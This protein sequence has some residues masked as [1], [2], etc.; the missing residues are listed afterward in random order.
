LCF[1]VGAVREPPIKMEYKNRKT[2]R[3]KDYD[4]SQNGMYFVTI[5]TKDR[6]CYFGDIVNKNM[7][8]S[9]MGKIV[10]RFWKEITEHFSFIEIDEYVVMPNHVHGILGVINYKDVGTRFIASK[11]NASDTNREDA[12]NRVPTGGVTKKNNPMLNPNSLSKIIRWYKGRCAFEIRNNN[13]PVTFAWQ[14]R[15]YDRIIR[16]ETEL[17]KIREYIFKNPDN[18]ERDRN[19]VENILM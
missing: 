4:Y 8:L 12:I 10:D 18:W 9:G 5:C 1:Y 19:N 2:T 11:N 15:F 17:N 7:T 13:V 3:L 14:S 6:E 16:N